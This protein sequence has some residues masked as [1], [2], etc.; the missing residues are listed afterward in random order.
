MIEGIELNLGMQMEEK[1]SDFMAEQR[2]EMK[3]I[4]E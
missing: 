4:R 1:L 2:E 3:G